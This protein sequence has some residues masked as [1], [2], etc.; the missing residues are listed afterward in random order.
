[1]RRHS[2]NRG[3]LI[4][5]ILF[6]ISTSS[7]GQRPPE[8]GLK[9]S[10][11]KNLKGQR[12]LPYSDTLKIKLD[13]GFSNDIVKIKCADK[14]FVTD[15]LNTNILFGFAGTLKLPK[16]KGKQKLRVYLNEIYIGELI[17]NKRFSEV[18]VDKFDRELKWTYINYRF[19]YL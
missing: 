15:T 11:R 17:L 10:I 13:R 1:M 4:T 12:P 2:K 16:E 6:L 8:T 3:V 14:Y 9:I 18:H 19:P 7:M 5:T